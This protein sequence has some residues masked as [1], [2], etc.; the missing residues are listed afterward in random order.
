MKSDKDVVS[1]LIGAASQDW[2]KDPTIHFLC[3]R[4]QSRPNR[5]RFRG[6]GISSMKRANWCICRAINFLSVLIFRD[7]F[8]RGKAFHCVSFCHPP[9]P[10]CALFAI[11]RS[12]Q[13]VDLSAFSCFL[14]CA[15]ILSS[16]TDAHSCLQRQGSA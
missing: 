16:E 4:P 6:R 2:M 11:F 14:P 1:L 12:R 3:R 15:S 5:S 9:A 8:E 13:R 7:S 10:C